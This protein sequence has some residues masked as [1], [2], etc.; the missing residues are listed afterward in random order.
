[1][2][3]IDLTESLQDS[4]NN[5]TSDAKILSF[6]VRV[7]REESATKKR[8]ALWRGFVS[9]VPNGKRHYFSSIKEVCEFLDTY[10][11]M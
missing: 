7:W 4:E 10:L 11:N 5:A 9:S 1:V 8:Q 2:K 6:I 3:E